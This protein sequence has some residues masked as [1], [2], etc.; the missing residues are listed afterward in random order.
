MH[1]YH[2]YH[3]DQSFEML[4]SRKSVH[5]P[6]SRWERCTGVNCVVNNLKLCKFSEISLLNH[7]RVPVECSK[8]D[9][10]NCS[11]Q[12]LRSKLDE[13]ISL[14]KISGIGKLTFLS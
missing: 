6:P 5:A 10:N 12:I 14:L 11:C 1:D 9:E 3:S 4:T 8:Y 13:I 7:S 2:I